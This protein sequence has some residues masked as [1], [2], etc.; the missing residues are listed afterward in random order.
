MSQNISFCIRLHK[1]IILVPKLIYR[2]GVF[3]LFFSWYAKLIGPNLIRVPKPLILHV[4]IF[5]CKRARTIPYSIIVINRTFTLNS[6]RIFPFFLAAL[7][8]TVYLTA[9]AINIWQDE[10][11]Q[12]HLCITTATAIS[13]YAKI[14]KYEQG[15]I[16]L[17]FFDMWC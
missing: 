8:W 10:Q 1:C 3:F 11:P 13:H 9:L 2:N 16:G 7:D 14:Q 5:T 15:K 17:Q 4:W 12:H 6:P